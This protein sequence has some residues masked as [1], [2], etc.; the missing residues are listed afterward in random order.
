L[1]STAPAAPAG[2][3]EGADVRDAK[4]AGLE[5]MLAVSMVGAAGLY[6]AGRTD[7]VARKDRVLP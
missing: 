1:A 6:A 7:T 4:T 5:A 2:H 3:R